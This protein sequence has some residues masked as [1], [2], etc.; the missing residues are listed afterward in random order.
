MAIE[1]KKFDDSFLRELPDIIGEEIRES[2]YRSAEQVAAKAKE[3][4]PAESGQLRDSIHVEKFKKANWVRV[5]SDARAKSDSQYYGRIVEFSPKINKP[6]MY[7]ALAEMENE[8]SDNIAKAFR[9]A[10]DKR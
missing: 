1:V 7:P 9:V 10:M 8:I 5:V 6:Y 4:C 3:K 2:L